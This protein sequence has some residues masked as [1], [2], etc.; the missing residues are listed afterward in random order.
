MH[1]F[2]TPY[3]NK[4]TGE[5]VK[6]WAWQWKAIMRPDAAALERFQQ[7]IQDTDTI[8]VFD[9]PVVQQFDKA[10][11]T[12]VPIGEVDQEKVAMF[13]VYNPKMPWQRYDVVMQP[14]MR[15]FFMRR[16]LTVGYLDM[17]QFTIFVFGYKQGNQHHYTYIMPDGRVY[18]SNE[19][20]VDIPNLLLYGDV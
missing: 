1:M 7:A 18:M 6:P 5:E 12:M 11:R 9:V 14:G 4:N 8:G 10:T 17:K 20:N 3:K 15:F 16:T 13:T 19:D 2:R